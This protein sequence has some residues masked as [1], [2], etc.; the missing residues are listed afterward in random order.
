MHIV[1]LRNYTNELGI[2][3]TKYL[4]ASN[5]AIYSPEFFCPLGVKAA[6]KRGHI[7]VCLDKNYIVAALRVYPRKKDTIV[8]LYQFAIH[9]NYRG[10]GLLQKMLKFTGFNK[11]EILCP[12]YIAFNFFYQKTGWVLTHSDDK[13]N[14]WII[15]F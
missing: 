3:F 7:I 12:K 10:Q 1:R 2:F 4:D 14:Y 6:A 13:Y 15:E 9:E 11:F 5:P 8:S